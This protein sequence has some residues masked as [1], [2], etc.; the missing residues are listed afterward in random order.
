MNSAGNNNYNNN[1]VRQTLTPTTIFPTIPTQTIQTTKNT[2]HLNL[3]THPVRPVGNL[4]IPQR[5][6]TLE[7]TQLIDRLPG[8]DGRKDR[9]QQ[10]IAQNNSDA[11]VQAAAQTL[12]YISHVFTQ[13]LH[14][15]DHRRVKQ[16][17]FHQLSFQ[18]VW[19]QPVEISINQHS[20]NNTDNDSIVKY[21][22][23]T[24]KT[25]VASQTLP[26]KGIQP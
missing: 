22:P 4:T 16:Q 24:S 26:T 9:I 10:R 21:T 23:E 18:L 17:N 19:Q 8:T 14:V 1:V 3:S 15:T 7:Q 5:N 11:N 2:K 6:V 13:E 25:T 12:N 20:L